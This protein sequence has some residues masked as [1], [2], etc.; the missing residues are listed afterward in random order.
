MSRTI[1]GAALALGLAVAVGCGSKSEQ[2]LP[3]AKLEEAPPTPPT[4]PQPPNPVAPKIELPKVA[5]EIDQTKH[6]IPA[7][8]V[9]GSI[10]SAEVTPEVQ[11]EG[12]EL[13][14]RSLKAGTMTV[15]RSVKLNLAP[16]LVAGQQPPPVLGREWKL[17]LDSAPGPG[18]PEVWR[19]VAGKNPHVYPTGYALTLELGPRKDGKVP[20]KIYLSLPDEEKTFL[21]GTFEA[22]YARPHTERPGPDDV[23]YIGG[24]VTVTGA[25]PN[26]EVRVTYAAFTPA[27]V[28]FKELQLPFDPVP[29]LQAR[30]TRDDTE[31]PRT[32][33]FVSGD[34]KGRP[35]RYEHI[36]LAPGRYLIAAAV[37]GGP[38]VW[39]WIDVAPGTA[40]V[41]NFT[42]DATKTGGVE[43]TVPAGTVGKVLLAPADAP[44]RPP[45]DMELY[46]AT[47]FQVVRQDTDIVG[48]K[49]LLKNLGP[50]KYEV[51]A[52]DLR[53]TVDVVAGKTVEFSLMPPKK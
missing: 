29:E 12:T 21:A 37:V 33:T 51:R 34:G 16:M 49:A 11:I 13:S 36:K 5:W 46:R 7:A 45:L 35:F 41:E 14:F 24:D 38:V 10:A 25:A 48:G 26:A 42:I 17:K 20:G 39:K 53:G 18:V 19:E 47:S 23:P 1:F 2:T 27:G 50:G 40:L 28:Y 4:G 15:E 8:A 44:E 32:S 31:R 52:G 30:W 6:A 9:K 3:S 22:A 43:V